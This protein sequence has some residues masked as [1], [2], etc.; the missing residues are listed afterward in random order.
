MLRHRIPHV[1]WGAFDGMGQLCV[2][3][4]LQSFAG[5]VV[6]RGFSMVMR[7]NAMMMGRLT[8][9]VRCLL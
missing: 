4:G 7:G 5:I 8:M 2:M 6:L 1:P 9:F 3:S